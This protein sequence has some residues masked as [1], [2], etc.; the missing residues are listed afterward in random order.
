MTVTTVTSSKFIS[1]PTIL[2][3]DFLR[4]NITDPISSSRQSNSKFVVTSY[5]QRP[6]QYPI[7]TVKSED[8][9][10]KNLG[11]QSTNQQM[12]IK[13][14]IRMWAKNEKQKDEL[15]Q[16]VHTALKNN[17]FQA[18]GPSSTNNLHDFDLISSVNI[19]EEGQRGIK[20][21]VNT[22]QWFAII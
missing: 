17:Q 14:E 8:F 7:I 9:T 22:Y 4:D 12:S 10:S 3:R 11:M 19:D 20:S 21:K 18:D 13:L 2:V 15:T 16:E 1:D 6:V 5:P